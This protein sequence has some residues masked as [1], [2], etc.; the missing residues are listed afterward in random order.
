MENGFEKAGNEVVSQHNTFQE[1]EE[2]EIGQT[3]F[4]HDNQKIDIWVDLDQL[5]EAEQE[6]WRV[7][8]KETVGY[9]E[10]DDRESEP[11]VGVERF[12]KRSRFGKNYSAVDILKVWY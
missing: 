7:E 8:E 9:L 11:S 6:V 3:Q 10:Q 12:P 5:E 4:D 2:S 1:K